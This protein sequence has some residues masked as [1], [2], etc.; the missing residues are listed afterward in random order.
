MVLLCVKDSTFLSPITLQRWGTHS[1]DDLMFC[2][3]CTRHIPSSLF[4]Y[5][6][7][8]EMLS[9]SYLLSALPQLDLYSYTSFPPIARLLARPHP[10][11]QTFVTSMD[12]S[13][14]EIK[15]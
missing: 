12:T 13:N 5:S 8:T 1:H 3:M 4:P 14:V 9:S 7:L 2:I 11:F 10:E 15:S 6:D